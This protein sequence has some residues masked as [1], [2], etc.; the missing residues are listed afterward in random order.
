MLA[1]IRALYEKLVQADA[2]KPPRPAHQKVEA[3]VDKTLGR[4]VK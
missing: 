4:L 1:W 3:D 2:A